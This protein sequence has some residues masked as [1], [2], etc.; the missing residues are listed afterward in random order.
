MRPLEIMEQNSWFFS[1]RFLDHLDPHILLIHEEPT[2][3]V[4]KLILRFQNGFG[5]EILYSFLGEE[6][7]LFFKVS[8][9]KFLGPRIKDFKP[10]QYIPIPPANRV[11]KEIMH[12][13][14]QVARLS[15]RAAA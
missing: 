4:H 13:C 10:V 6:K 1:G 8:V 2:E 14:Q 3:A 9:L 7:P 15:A 12:V 5:I 11:S